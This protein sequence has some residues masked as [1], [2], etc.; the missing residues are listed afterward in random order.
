MPNPSHNHATMSTYTAHQLA[1]SL[2]RIFILYNHAN[3]IHSSLTH[4]HSPTDWCSF[5]NYLIYHQSI[6]SSPSCSNPLL[7][8]YYL[9]FVYPL[10]SSLAL[11]WLNPLLLMEIPFAHYNL[12]YLTGMGLGR[13]NWIVVRSNFVRFLMV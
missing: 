13:I 10:R 11:A 5:E 3:F 2:S 1:Y 8:I 9:C 7:P 6:H 4:S 12:H